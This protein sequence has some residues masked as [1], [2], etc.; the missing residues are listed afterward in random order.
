M[1]SLSRF[2]RL[3]APEQ[4][5]LVEAMFLLAA[6][7][8]GLWLLPFETVRR[9]LARVARTPAG[10]REV[11]LPSTQSVVWAVTVASRYVPRAGSGACLTQAL[12]AQTMLARRGHQAL[13]RIGLTKDEERRLQ[14]HAWVES[15]GEVVIGGSADLECFTPLPALEGD[16]P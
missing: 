7:G 16:R 8:P 13:L 10:L 4:R 12:A 11:D 5:L 1:H 9:L 2:V 14:A 6:I 3:S 15:E